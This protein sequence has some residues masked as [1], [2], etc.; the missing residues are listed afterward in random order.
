MRGG[1]LDETRRVLEVHLDLAG[2]DLVGTAASL[3][4]TL[5]LLITWPLASLAVCQPEPGIAPTFGE[6]AKAS[7]HRATWTGAS[8]RA[9]RPS[10]QRGD[11]SRT[12][13]GAR[14]GFG[15]FA[16]TRCERP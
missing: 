10:G 8:R 15:S 6:E 11:F 3:I 1:L 12:D 9:G 5:L 14:H 16:E 2:S 7:A 4:V 13:R